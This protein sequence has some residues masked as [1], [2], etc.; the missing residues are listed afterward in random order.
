M[1]VWINNR[2]V[3]EEEAKV[4][5]FDYGFLFGYGLFETL[6]AYNG[7]VFRLVR[8]LERMNEA[9]KSLGISSDWE[10]N[11]IIEAV[12]NTIATNNLSN[13]YIRL[14]IWKG[15]GE[16]GLRPETVKRVNLAIIAR[17]FI[18]YP[19]RLYKEGMSAVIVNTRRGEGDPISHMK[20]FNYLSNILA[21]IEAKKAGA[22]EALL[23]NHRGNVAC[24]AVSNIFLVKDGV[25]LTPPLRE[26][27]LGGITRDAIIEA[28]L[29]HSEMAEIKEGDISVSQLRDADE[30]FLTNT[31]M[32]VMPLTRINGLSVKDGL[33]GQL[34]KVFSSLYKKLIKLGT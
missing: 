18:P 12:N 4:S 17:P 30:V 34:T 21:R 33:P 19:S 8:H 28:A 16:A 32:E 9:E 23:L 2:L 13:A 15:E 1:K 7:K 11:E 6:R 10:E 22:D 20:T 27:V 26:G 5:I 31:L 14:N 3:P 29:K 25:V 24:G